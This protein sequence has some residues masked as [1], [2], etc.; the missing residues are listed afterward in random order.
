MQP[1]VVPTLGNLPP[2]G[3]SN[4]PLSVPMPQPAGVT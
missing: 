4:V 3:G 2:M 1:P